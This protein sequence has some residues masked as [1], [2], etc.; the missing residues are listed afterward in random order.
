M[1]GTVPPLRRPC[2]MPGPSLGG[3]DPTEGR[4]LV[5]VADGVHVATSPVYATT[6]TVLV[7]AGGCCLVVDPAVTAA[8]V[9]GI[10]G[11]VH[12]RGWRPVAVWSTHPHW[13]HLLDGPGLTDLPRW[14]ASEPDAGWRERAQAQRDGDPALAAAPGDGPA[15]ITTR[16]PM[17]F[18]G[19]QGQA[20]ADGTV[21]LAWDGP[22]VRVLRHDAHS[23]G[24]TALVVVD[25]GVLIAGDLLSD[26]EVPL[27]DGPVPEHRAVLD[28]LG[29][30]VDRY[31]L[32]VV[33]PGH[34]RVGAPGP[35]LAADR[36]Y[37][38]GLGDPAATDPRLGGSAP[39][40]LRA[41][42]REQR[43]G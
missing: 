21:R 41:V 13:D 35:R 26:V 7:G 15:P 11:Q 42:D 25:A 28:R 40:W 5:E 12:A 4:T 31:R 36:A 33:V 10:T 34:G 18:P 43:G 24:H 2:V 9:A 37:L 16:A 8:D 6:T 14:A 39:E 17:R 3:M 30:L 29:S 23:V 20:D 38:G 19:A 1:S 32:G 22:E 27:L